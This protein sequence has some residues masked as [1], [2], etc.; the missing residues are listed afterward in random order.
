MLVLRNR[1]RMCAWAIAPALLAA[2]ASHGGGLPPDA[3]LPTGNGMV[4]R[5]AVPPD[6]KGQKTTGQYA[7]VTQTLSTSGGSL[8]IPAFGGFG[9]KVKY[10]TASPS[11]QITLTSSTTNY[12]KMPELGDGTAIFYLQLGLSGGTTF[13]SKVRAGGGLASSTL[14]PGQPYTAYGEAVIYGFKVKFGPCYTVAKKSKFGGSIGGLGTLLKGQ[15][16]P[17]AASGVIEVYSGQQTAA[18]C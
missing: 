18:K 17:V 1:L 9:G 6:C 11:V 8:C 3:L 4:Q 14:V 16:V 13:G 12:N 5:L 2:C 10:P 15:D 7:S